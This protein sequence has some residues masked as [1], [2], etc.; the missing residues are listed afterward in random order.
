MRSLFS[1]LPIAVALAGCA[2]SPFSVNP[3]DALLISATTGAEEALAR[4]TYGDTV[5]VSDPDRPGLFRICD[6]QGEFDG[7]F[8]R[9]D[10]NAD[11]ALAGA[12]ADEVD[13]RHPER[14]EVGH[15]MHLLRL[16]YDLDRDG[17]LS[18]AEKA[19]LF[20][21]FTARC[22][23]L[24]AR[25]L[26]EFDA[27][28]D[29]VL[30]EAEQAVAAAA[31]LAAQEAAEAERRDDMEGECPGMDSDHPEG[32]HPHGDHDGH[33]RGP[34][35][36]AADTDRVP[37]P[38]AGFDVDGDGLWGDAELTAFREA[39]RAAIRN[40]DPLGGPRAG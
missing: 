38:L 21:D 11:G 1:V 12:E 35:D 40:G 7:L 22:D 34:P 31:V 13:G 26:A 36:G 39:M 17:A 18:D 33:H 16:V 19:M 2:T 5:G 14:S 23:A 32:D 20:D 24:H 9:Y 10:A 8:V 27:D 15:R 6:A 37:P 4:S 28:K 25:L 30:S 29:G 3:E